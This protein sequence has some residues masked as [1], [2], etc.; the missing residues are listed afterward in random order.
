M[1]PKNKKRADIGK[2]TKLGWQSFMD[3]HKKFC[4][5]KPSSWVIGHDYFAR[6]ITTDFP[7]H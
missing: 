7:G 5:A 6:C 3:V 2:F 4:T 1:L